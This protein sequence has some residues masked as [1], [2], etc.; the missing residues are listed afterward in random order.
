M[1]KIGALPS[2][3]IKEMIDAGFIKNSNLSALQPA[4]L[5]LRI[6]DEL[7][8]VS[9]TFTPRTDERIIDAAKRLAD[10]E[11]REID[12]PLEVGVTYLARLQESLELPKSVYGYANPKSTSG[13]N[14]IHVRLLADGMQRF[15]SAGV[16]GYK[17][18]L[19]TLITPRSFRVKLHEGNSLQQMRFFNH[20]TRFTTE[21]EIE[22]AYQ[23]YRLLF[24]AKGKFIPYSDIR[25]KDYDGSLILT[26]NLDR[27]L[28]AYRCEGNDN[29]LDFSRNDHK[30]EDF[31]E[32][33]HRPKSGKLN[34][35]KGDF[36]FIISNSCSIS[37][38]NTS[39][40]NIMFKIT[41]LNI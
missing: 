32:P 4:S 35:R 22:V 10:P 37:R 27:D 13:R 20:D 33:I 6:S 16:K 21:Q 40:E 5:D 24:D 38:C 30:V 34:L 41:W 2:Q 29:V 1:K 25:I 39:C 9:S 8:R 31:F 23:K 18:G 7:Y 3:E 36:G 11:P 28:V 15:D 12:D 19:W 26:V 17:G 14:D